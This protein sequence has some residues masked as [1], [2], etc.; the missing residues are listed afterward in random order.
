V[1]DSW[2]GLRLNRELPIWHDFEEFEKAAE[3]DWLA[4][5]QQAVELY[6]GPYLDNI[7]MPRRRHSLGAW[8]AGQKKTTGFEQ[9]QSSFGRM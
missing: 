6:P 2:P 8:G 5:W 4:A 3:G 1:A 9:S 7:L